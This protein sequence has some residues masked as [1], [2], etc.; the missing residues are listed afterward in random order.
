MTIIDG[1]RMALAAIRA[2][3]M[4]S[5]LTVLGIV[6]G[7]AA[8]IT[9]VAMG[10]GA[11]DQVQQQVSSIGANLIMVTPGVRRFGGVAVSGNAILSEE[12]AAAI[13]REV[14][15]IAAVAPTR[16]GNVQLV[17]GNAN[18]TSRLEGITEDYMVAR[19]W[20]IESGRS[21]S[22]SEV[23][24]G[25]QV[26]LLGQTVA[27]ELFG[28]SDPVGQSIRINRTPAT[29]VGLLKSKGQTSFGQDQDRIVM[30]PLPTSRRILGNSRIQPRRVD[31]ITVKAE[32]G[33]R[34]GT[35]VE[36]IKDLLRQRLR[37][38]PGGTDTFEVRNLTEF[39]SAA[40][41]A[42]QTMTMLVS[43]VASVSLLVGG[44][45]IMNI[46]LVSVTER[47]REIGLRL[48]VGARRGD[49]LLQFL[50]EA[51]TLC[52]IGGAIGIGLGI[53]LAYLI[54]NLAQWPVLVQPNVIVMSVLISAAIGVFFGFWPARRAAR[55]DPIEAL[56]FE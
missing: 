18:S 7:V 35:A 49:I 10:S 14:P 20:T 53:G 41:E 4:R 11:R 26:V 38:P 50:V 44:I 24:T 55:L 46:M 56:R 22:S 43:A 37:I 16:S 33:G 12:D 32:S 1:I 34:L 21:L 31:T 19:E 25:G 6:I 47:T 8:V 30:V 36:D 9:M 45:G 5:L 48:A 13:I 2:N 28:E 39:L 23:R 29:V 27:R 52:I 17:A 54:G 3:A 15:G 40:T 42:T 51:V